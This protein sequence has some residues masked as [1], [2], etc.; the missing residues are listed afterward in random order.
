MPRTGTR[1][2]RRAKQASL[3]LFCLLAFSFFEEWN[4]SGNSLK[5]NSSK[6]KLEGKK[7]KKSHVV[8][9]PYL[10]A[11]RH[12]RQRPAREARA[13]GRHSESSF[14]FEFVRRRK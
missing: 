9:S 14:E 8:T 2:G 6:K 3:S 13:G 1:G 7:L 4:R 5:K 11:P 12:G 10:S